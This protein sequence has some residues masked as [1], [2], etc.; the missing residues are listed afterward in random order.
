M[1]GQSTTET[2]TLTPDA[3]TP[4]NSFLQATLT[5]TYGPSAT[6][7]TQTLTIP[8]QVVVPG[9]DA[10]GNASLVATQVGNTDLA[11]VLGDLSTALTNLVQ[12]PTSAVDNGQVT[13]DL[14][15][16]AGQVAADPFLAGRR[17]P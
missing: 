17:P 5:A 2:I 1:P 7:L 15:S 13:A 10:I 6:P 3:S 4:L 14:A 12:N 8:V 16:I 11:T 9:A